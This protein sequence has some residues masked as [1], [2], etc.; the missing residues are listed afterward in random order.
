[1]HSLAVTAVYAACPATNTIDQEARLADGCPMI[2][3]C[4]NDNSAR[5]QKVHITLTEIGPDRI[6]A[7]VTVREVTQASKFVR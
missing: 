4:H 7:R 2:E 1:M 3:L 6:R 5:V